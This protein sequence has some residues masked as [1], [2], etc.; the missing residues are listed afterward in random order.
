MA[1]VKTNYG[2]MTIEAVLILTMLLGLSTFVANE[3][4]NNELLIKFVQGPWKQISGMA[5]NGTWG[6]PGA[7]MADH[8]NNFNRSVSVRGEPVN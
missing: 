7:T 5:Q 1:N 3:F 6:Q 2:Q 4:R 8:P